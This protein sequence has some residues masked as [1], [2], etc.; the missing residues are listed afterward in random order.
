MVFSL[1]PGSCFIVPSWK[2]PF[3][4]K[5]SVYEF[6]IPRKIVPIPLFPSSFHPRSPFCISTLEIRACQLQQ[7]LVFKLYSTRQCSF[8]Y[9]FEVLSPLHKSR[10]LHS[11][12]STPFYI[13]F[14][15]CSVW[16]IPNLCASYK[17]SSIYMNVRWNS[18][19][20]KIASVTMYVRD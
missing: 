2:L 4:L 10:I 14:S 12:S 15:L 9:M 1:L 3:S 8:D 13:D 18:K 19:C 17:C 20:K 16:F 7:P 11:L 6:D 5:S